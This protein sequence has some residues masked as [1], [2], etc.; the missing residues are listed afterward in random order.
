[1]GKVN[2]I[3]PN[4]RT[5]LS[6]GEVPGWTE[7]MILCPQCGHKAKAS[8]YLNSAASGGRCSREDET[9]I[10]Q[11]ITNFDAGQIRVVKSGQICPLKM[12]ENVIGRIASSGRADIQI[13]HDE[14][15]SR[16][17]L[18]ID[19]VK[20]PN[21]CEHHLVEINSTNIVILNGKQIGR[22]DVL[23]LK[24]G[25]RMTLGKTEVIF[26]ETEATVLT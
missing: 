16:R 21:G 15:M 1:M 19:V 7:K 8:V 3:C 10:G 25:D 9:E 23:R 24:F 5:R 17:H 20:T 26:E 2:L 18:Q 6:F 13:T 22:G 14:Y 12:G 4:C 11:K